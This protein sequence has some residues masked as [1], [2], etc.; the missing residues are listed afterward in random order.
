MFSLSNTRFI[1]SLCQYEIFMATIPLVLHAA[2][3]FDFIINAKA[4]IIP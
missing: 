2:I 1:A 4:F 3:P